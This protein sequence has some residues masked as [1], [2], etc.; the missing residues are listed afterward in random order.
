MSTRG[1]RCPCA[2]LTG[3]L[4]SLQSVAKHCGEEPWARD[5]EGW[6]TFFLT[7]TGGMTIDNTHHPLCLSSLI[8]KVGLVV[9]PVYGHLGGSAG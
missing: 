2:V 5:S 8:H 9:I 7:L 3:F 1:L 6:V 4:T